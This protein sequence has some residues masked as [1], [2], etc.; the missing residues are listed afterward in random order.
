MTARR[1]LLGVDFETRLFGPGNMTPK[2]IC[3]TRSMR[4]H[5]PE[6]VV[7]DFLPVWFAK[8]LDLSSYDAEVCRLAFHNAAYD[9]GCFVANC[10]EHAVTV[11]RALEGGGV[12]CTMIREQLLDIARG[13]MAE[14]YSLKAVVARRYDLELE[15]DEFR[16][17]F[18]E[19]ENLPLDDWPKG[20]IEYAQADA[21]FAR[22]IHDEQTVDAKKIGYEA[23][24]EEST[25]QTAFDFA[26]RSLSSRG[27]MLDAE[28]VESELRKYEN[29]ENGYIESL[30]SNNVFHPGTTTRNMTA[31]QELVEKSY[32]GGEP[33]TT[34]KTGKTKTDAETIAECPHP[35]LITY[36]NFQTVSKLLSTYLR[37]MS[38]RGS[39]PIHA[40]FVTLMKSGRTSC[41]EPNLQNLPRVGGVRECVVPREGF[42]F[43]TA[44]Y[45]SQE[46]R[47][48]GQVC[49]ILLGRSTIA[50]RYSDD[51]DFDP[52]SDFA[53]R[54]LG[55]K[56]T[57][58]LKRKAAGDEEF[59]ATRQRAKAA[60]FGFP[61][62]MS[63][64]TFVRKCHV[65]GIELTLDEA[66]HLRA[67]WLRQ[68]P[69]MSAYF[70]AVKDML[71]TSGGRVEQLV[72]GRVRGE[73]EFTVGANTLFQGLAADASK[74]ALYEVV[75]TTTLGTGDLAGSF[76]VLF[77]HDEIIIEAPVD[78]A[79]EAAEELARVM[80]AAM[81]EVCPDVPARASATLMSRW[82]K[83]AQAIRDGEG[84]LIPWNEN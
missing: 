38:E 76:P 55:L 9:L 78:T 24:D 42:V 35:A 47:T 81:A 54:M 68:W 52:H 14:S 43:A 8:L 71:R 67:E 1:L 32:P 63:P 30:R 70:R 29:L 6:I 61:V 82:S 49:K 19:F 72:S 27:V 39:G 41:R 44:D 13:P 79:S 18:E 73:C 34:E 4:G 22:R 53:A 64:K 74:N 31:I 51:P 57:E 33:P 37:P 60:N 80:E 77:V 45:D 20:A 12:H 10:P 48:L 69:E 66:E 84:R 3:A 17:R 2:P 83:K 11:F 46:I 40:G 36:S 58:G 56:Y 28:R 75:K 7:G 21:D 25:R 23:F 50:D 59:S 16:T 5:D 65:D 62:G 15:K 26:L